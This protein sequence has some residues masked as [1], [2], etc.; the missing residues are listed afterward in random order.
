MGFSFEE[1]N[2]PRK[3]PLCTQAIHENTIM[4]I[5]ILSP[6]RGVGWIREGFGLFRLNPLI[7][8]LMSLI[9]LAI[10]SIISLIPFIGP[11]ALTLIQPVLSGGLMAGCRALDEGGELR[12]E[13]LFE[14]FQRKTQTLLMVGLLTLAAYLGVGVLSIAVF[15]ILGAVSAGLGFLS[16]GFPSFSM[17]IGTPPAF[18]GL[19]IGGL[20]FL[21]LFVPITMATWF[22]PALV[23]FR[24]LSAFEAMKQSF[25]G[26]WRNILPFLLYGLAILVL[27][28]LALLPLGLGLLILG[29]TLVGSVYVAYRDIFPDDEPQ[30]TERTP[31][32]STYKA[33]GLLQ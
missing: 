2:S 24:G 27:A 26:C 20:I 28:F 6:D 16:G 33:N 32:D 11:S 3:A 30:T 5:R 19:L 23:W 13:Y 10:S 31:L 17:P 7:W 4:N 22:A 8:I 14:G 12:I 25:V 9:Y 1:P 15:L 18:S 21:A 29:P